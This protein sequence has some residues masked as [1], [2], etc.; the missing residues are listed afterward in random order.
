MAGVCGWH[1]E[2][3]GISAVIQDAWRGVHATSWV[4]VCGVGRRK[5]AGP[6]LRSP[7]S[8]CLRRQ[9][10]AC[11]HRQTLFARG[12]RGTRGSANAS[13]FRERAS[14]SVRAVHLEQFSRGDAGARGFRCVRRRSVWHAKSYLLE[15]RSARAVFSA[16]AVSPRPRV[17][18]RKLLTILTRVEIV[19]SATTLRTSPRPS[20]APREK[21]S[22]D[23]KNER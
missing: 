14:P 3:G 2:H 11:R 1:A 7:T 5:A 8:A 23:A 18:A 6:V 4:G 12:S 22:A 15:L 19:N 10:Y 9:F 16:F 20:R 17:P 13:A 21:C